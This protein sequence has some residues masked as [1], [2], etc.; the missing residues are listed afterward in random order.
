MKPIDRAEYLVLCRA[1][2]DGWCLADARRNF[3][4]FVEIHDQLVEAMKSFHHDP[5]QRDINDKCLN[6]GGTLTAFLWKLQSAIEENKSSLY[7]LMD[8]N[9]SS[10][11]VFLRRGLIAYC[12][13]VLRNLETLEVASDETMA[14]PLK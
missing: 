1:R 6:P 8:F 5:L 11:T 12:T 9:E 13:L 3:A 2:W 14:L 10:Q 4:D 7:P